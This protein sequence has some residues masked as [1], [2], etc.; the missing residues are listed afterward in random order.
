MAAATLQVP[1]IYFCFCFSFYPSFGQ[2]LQDVR[3]FVP[4]K[5]KASNLRKLKVSFYHK[6][7]M[8]KKEKIFVKS[9]KPESS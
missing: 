6:L 8:K 7:T 2:K 4:S 5:Q 3:A 9:W 1:G